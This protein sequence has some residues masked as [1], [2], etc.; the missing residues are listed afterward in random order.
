MQFEGLQPGVVWLAVLIII[1]G[2]TE[3]LS[4]KLNTAVGGALDLLK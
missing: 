4:G 3:V 1:S 2:R